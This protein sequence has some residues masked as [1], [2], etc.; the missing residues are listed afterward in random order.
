M[1]P[2]AAVLR[3][4]WVQSPVSHH[5]MLYLKFSPTSPLILHFLLFQC[6]S[7][8]ATCIPCFSSPDFSSCSSPSP[9]PAKL[10]QFW[11]FFSWATPVPG[12]GAKLVMLADIPWGLAEISPARYFGLNLQTCLVE[13]MP[14]SVPT[15]C[16]L[17]PWLK[18]MGLLILKGDG[19]KT[20]GEH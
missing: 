19:F 15:G 5:L 1:L 16:M 13:T 9:H 17:L 2:R 18:G 8:L 10:S 3:L 6:I 12:H 14:A 7:V 11:A 20:D 4:S